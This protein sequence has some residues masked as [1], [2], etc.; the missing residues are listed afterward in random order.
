MIAVGAFACLAAPQPTVT[1][2]EVRLHGCAAMPE[3]SADHLD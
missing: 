1:V 3:L 2:Y